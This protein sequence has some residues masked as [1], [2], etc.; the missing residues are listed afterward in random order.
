MYPEKYDPNHLNGASLSD[1]G[2]ATAQ[3]LWLASR[4]QPVH[5]L[6]LEGATNLPAHYNPADTQVVAVVMDLS[7]RMV[8]ADAERGAGLL[9]ASGSELRDRLVEAGLL[10]KT[11]SKHEKKVTCLG[12]HVKRVNDITHKANR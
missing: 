12:T 3:A 7:K 8:V 6:V 11:V 1:A 9:F 2:R 5:A 10:R 4:N